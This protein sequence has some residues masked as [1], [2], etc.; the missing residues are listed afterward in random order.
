MIDRSGNVACAMIKN[1]VAAEAGNQVEAKPKSISNVKIMQT[2]RDVQN[3]LLIIVL[4]G[5]V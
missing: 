4:V 1:F 5:K 2:K 3:L